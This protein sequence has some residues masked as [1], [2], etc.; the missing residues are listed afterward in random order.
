MAPKAK[1]TAAVFQ[2]KYADLVSL[3]Y[4]HCKTA[5]TLQAALS[6]RKP[7]ITVSESMLKFWMN[8]HRLPEDAI[9][10]CSANELNEKYGSLVIDLY[11]EN[12]T[13]YKLRGALLKHTPPVC[14]SEQVLKQWLKMYKQWLKMYTS[15]KAA[16]APSVPKRPA[17]AVSGDLRNSIKKRPAKQV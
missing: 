15:C 4:T 3:E 6:Q 8:N 5:Y 10:V 13:A 11:A 12:S 1:L 2:Q 17:A 16:D 7:P 14:A 9:K